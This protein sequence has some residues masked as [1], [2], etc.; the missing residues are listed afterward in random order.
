MLVKSGNIKDKIEY[1]SFGFTRL[2]GILYILAFAAFGLGDSISGLWMIGERGMMYEAN[3]FARYII[4]EHGLL[5]LIEFKIWITIMC[6]IIPFIAQARSHGSN[7]WMINGYLVSFIVAGALATIMNY[8]AAHYEDLFLSPGQVVIIFLSSIC[9]LTY[10][11]EKI[12]S[13]TGLKMRGYFESLKHD[14]V[15]MV[16]IIWYSDFSTSILKKKMD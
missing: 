12:D 13:L 7:Y 6:L 5:G 2:Q 16:S 11:G 1:Y 14:A 15:I 9:L 8:R 3:P 4:Y 10:I